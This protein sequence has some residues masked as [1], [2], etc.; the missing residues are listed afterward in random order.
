M[1]GTSSQHLLV[2]NLSFAGGGPGPLRNQDGTSGRQT[3]FTALPQHEDNMPG[4]RVRL[5]LSELALGTAH[6]SPDRPDTRVTCPQ[7]STG[8][9]SLATAVHDA[10]GNRAE[11]GACLFSWF[12]EQLGVPQCAVQ[13]VAF[14]K[15]AMM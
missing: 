15:C 7:V 2:S 13:M 10:P 4:L 3:L 1:P 11:P 9:R 12:L 6:C 14:A 8:L 5:V